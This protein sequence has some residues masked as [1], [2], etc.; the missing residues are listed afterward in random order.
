MLLIIVW[1]R[2]TKSSGDFNAGNS[3]SITTN[4]LNNVSARFRELIQKNHFA[5]KFPEFKI[6]RSLFSLSSNNI[7][8]IK[9]I[10]SAKSKNPSNFYY[11]L[12]GNFIQ[13]DQVITLDD[14]PIEIKNFISKVYISVSKIT[15]VTY[16]DQ[17]QFYL[18]NGIN[19]KSEVT[20]AINTNGKVIFER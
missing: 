10:A 20:I 4:E 9:I 5:N 19:K 12:N 1:L 15:L 14:L 18:I 2:V 16:A 3:R 17:R 6:E 11:S 13:R 8:L 7:L